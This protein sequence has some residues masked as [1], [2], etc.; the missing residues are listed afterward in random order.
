MA[1]AYFKLVALVGNMRSKGVVKP[2]PRDSKK[3][4]IF[5]ILSQILADA[6]YVV[7][8]EELK[9]GFGWKVVSGT[10]RLKDDKIVFVDRRMS[11]EDQL[12]FLSAKIVTLG[13]SVTAEHTQELSELHWSLGTQSD[14]A[15]QEEGPRI[16]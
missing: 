1:T 12:S 3:E 8:R 14:T 15:T 9:R 11:Q 13:I 10:C 7:R 5:K 6:G 16:S 4:K 2:A